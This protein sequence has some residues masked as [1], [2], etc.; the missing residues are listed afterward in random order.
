M[1]RTTYTSFILL[2]YPPFPGKSMNHNHRFPKNCAT[3]FLD[4][5]L[6]LKRVV[7]EEYSMLNYKFDYFQKRMSSFPLANVETFD[8]KTFDSYFVFWIPWILAC[9]T[10][11]IYNLLLL[12]YI[13]I[14][15]GFRDEAI[16]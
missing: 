7:M 12:C 14:Y 11:R 1:S 8:N 5:L 6:W 2:Y 3:L 10:F 15:A 13:C 4:M 16:W 9:T